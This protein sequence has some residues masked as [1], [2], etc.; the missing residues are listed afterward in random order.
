MPAL[1]AVICL[2]LLLRGAVPAERALYIYRPEAR[3]IE[4]RDPAWLP[5]VRIPLSS[6]PRTVSNPQPQ[7]E[8]WLLSLDEAIRIALANSRVVRILAG[9]SAVASGSTIYDPAI[10]N[11]AIDE[12]QA[13][14][15]P[16]FSVDNTFNQFEPPV[17]VFD[18]NNPFRSIIAGT[19][20]ESYDLD[21]SLS[22]RFVSGGELTFDLPSTTSRF[23]PGLFPLNPQT[24][25]SPAISLVQPLLQGGGAA[26]NLAPVVIA[27]IETERSF[28][29]LKGSVQDLVQDVVQG[30]WALVFARTDLWARRQQVEQSQFALDRAEARRQ[31]GFADIAEVA[32]TRVALANFRAD[33][34]AAEANLL[35]TEAALRNL[36]GLPPND[37]RVIVPTTPPSIQRLAFDWNALV[38]LAEQR[39]PDVI[40]LKLVLE[41]DQQQLLVARNQA[42]PRLDGVAL[43]RWNGLEGR[44]PDGSF[45]STQ[46]G[47]FTDWTLGVN[48]SVPLGLRQGRAALRRQE[49]LI[50]RD[51]ANIEQA[52]HA[53]IHDLAADVRLHDSRFEQYQAFRVT[54]E[55]A[56]TNLEQQFAEYSFGRIIFLN[57]LN[58]IADWGAAVSAEAR[59]LTD[60]NTVLTVLERD[61]GTILETHGVRFY[62]ERYASIGPLGLARPAACY[63][64]A[65]VPTPNRN[66]YPDS[67]RPAEEFFNLRSPVT[68]ESNAELPPPAE[69][70]PALQTP[71]RNATPSGP[72][73]RL[74]RQ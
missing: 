9:T 26:V 24:S 56:Q 27:R 46:G 38:G 55:A 15:D 13:V 12:R 11:A 59:S 50:D 51:R 47:Q 45:V 22:K 19:S 43:Y 40:E 66:L 20:T 35:D 74:W 18:P 8:Q 61:T 52:V 17:A 30:Y 64:R 33:R 2:A 4:V 14:F 28:F 1:T 54:R 21:L 37:L 63:P 48:F 10:A 67:G 70:V 3:S 53:A 68:R 69:Q 62:E 73:V 41:A 7:T 25:A 65:E 29:Q 31:A 39:R 5:R 71:P 34:I 36:L 6:P 49:L 58:A 42:L 32:Q 44:M 60:Y 72:M 57:V 16:V 23:S